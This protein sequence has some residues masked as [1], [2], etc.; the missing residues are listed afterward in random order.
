MIAPTT[1]TLEAKIRAYVAAGSGLDPGKHVIPGNDKGP[2]PKELY[3]TVLLVTST[4]QGV[5]YRIV[6]NANVDVNDETVRTVRAQYS[7]QWFRKGARDAAQQFATWTSSFAGIQDAA[8]RRLTFLGVSAVRQI[9][10]IVS[11]DWEERA[12]VDLDV[13]YL[14]SVTQQTTAIESVGIGFA[15]D[16][17]PAVELEIQ[18]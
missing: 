7:V 18:A 4:G 9:D 8:E 1:A 11:D 6:S 5:P 2:A 17:G 3:A 12:G 15:P 10:L 13:G 16:S 14:E